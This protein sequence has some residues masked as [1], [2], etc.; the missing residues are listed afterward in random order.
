VLLGP[1]DP[2]P[3][4]PRRILINGNAGA[5]KTTLAVAVG[6]QLGLPHTELDGLFHGP[7]WEPRAEFLDDV[8][9]LVAG[10]RWIAEYQYGEAHP[11]LL[12][13]GDLMIWLDPPRRVSMWRV[14]RRTLRR[15]F[16][17]EVLWNGN[18][19]GPLHH[20]FRDP[21]HIIRWAWT[22]HPRAAQRIDLVLRERP[23]L[24]VVRLR[25][26]AEVARWRASLARLSG[27]GGTPG[28][29]R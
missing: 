22:S 11:L 10:E 14:I 21:E 4:L 29:P 8:A 13:R 15:R 18:V 16:R 7:G 12:A 17:R 26:D 3:S 5:G 19:E 25:S 28:R 20:I 23:E 2:L 6:A 1:D 24:P 27:P 9:A